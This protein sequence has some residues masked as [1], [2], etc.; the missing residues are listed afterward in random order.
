MVM[1]AAPTHDMLCDQAEQRRAM[2]CVDIAF[3]YLFFC[4]VHLGEETTQ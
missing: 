3:V 1:I 2:T 4:N